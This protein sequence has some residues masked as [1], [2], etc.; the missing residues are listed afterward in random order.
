MVFAALAALHYRN[1]T[2]KGQFIDMSQHENLIGQLGEVVMD[3]TMNGRI[4]KTMGNR[5]PQAAPCGCYRCKGEDR[6]VNITVYSDEEWQGFCHALGNPSWT[7]DVRFSNTL[8]R[9]KNQDDLDKYVEK[10]TLQHDNYE[11]MEILQ[12][13]GVP[14]A[15]VMNEKDCF[16]DPHIKA[17]HFYEMATHP[18]AGPAPDYGPGTHLYP[19]VAWKLSKTPGR[20]YR[21]PPCLGEHNEYVYKQLIGVSEEE[22]AELEKEGHIGMDFAEHVF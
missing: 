19:G 10:W 22:Y 15:P 4:Q 20:I 14:S 3:Y 16:E 13:E 8:S 11:V 17:R 1:R 5:D 6:W 9:W 2:G 18:E 7:K 21:H 12:K